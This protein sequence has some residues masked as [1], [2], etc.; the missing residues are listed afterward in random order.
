[1]KSR[2]SAT[3]M[4]N[5]SP[6]LRICLLFFLFE[7]A[8]SPSFYSYRSACD[9]V[10]VE[11]KAEFAKLAVID[12]VGS[13]E[14][15]GVEVHSGRGGVRIAG[16]EGVGDS[17]VGSAE[18]A[19][20]GTGVTVVA[21]VKV[22]LGDVAV[23]VVFAGLGELVVTSIPVLA[24]ADDPILYLTGGIAFGSFEGFSHWGQPCQEPRR[25]KPR[26]RV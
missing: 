6:L 16:V 20:T 15:K 22:L 17:E 8:G 10:A 18:L 4:V 3:V 1:M 24:T 21:V 23:L 5:S 9:G 14:E 7:G 11:Q 13:S 12:G 19:E 26:N 25:D 2:A